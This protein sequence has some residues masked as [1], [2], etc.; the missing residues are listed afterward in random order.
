MCF[1]N[2]E[3]SWFSAAKNDDLEYIVKNVKK[4]GRS[5]DKRKTDYENHIYNGFTALHYACMFGC[6]HLLSLLLLIEYDILTSEEQL[7]AAPGISQSSK[8]Q[9]LKGSNFMQIAMLSKN[10]ELIN[11]ALEYIN[12]IDN[13][14]WYPPICKIYSTLSIASICAYEEASIIFKTQSIIESEIDFQIQG[15]KTPLALSAKYANHFAMKSFLN[16]C[17]DQRY[18]ASVFYMALQKDCEKSVL[19]LINEAKCGDKSKTKEYFLKIIEK[20]SND[21]YYGQF[22]KLF[23]DSPNNQVQTTTL[24]FENNKQLQSKSVLRS[25]SIASKKSIIIPLSR[26]A[27]TNQILEDAGLINDDG[28]INL[29]AITA[30][31]ISLIRQDLG[32]DDSFIQPSTQKQLLMKDFVEATIHEQVEQ[33]NK[34]QQTAEIPSEYSL[35]QE[36]Q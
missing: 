9:L 36:K 17:S 5:I 34:T 2:R 33:E 4:M 3:Y 27:T 30:S 1:S 13:F 6:H 20:A 23:E 10:I 7:I 21:Q 32:F 19:N 15:L 12:Y 35:Y 24:S 26:R 16:L 11:E 18:K 25:K 31:K 28:E 22:A 14:Q 29:L 8:F